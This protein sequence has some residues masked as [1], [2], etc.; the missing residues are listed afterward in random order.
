MSKKKRSTILESN[1]EAGGVLIEPVVEV[2][3]PSTNGELHIVF[4]APMGHCDD[5]YASGHLE[6]GSMLPR[7]AAALKR[8]RCSLAEQ[9]AR[10]QRRDAM[11]RDGKVVDS[12]ADAIRWILDQCADRFEALGQD[13]LEGQKF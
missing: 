1:S 3:P 5:G 4:D 6:V 11:H 12:N 10:T 8:I 9:A 7:Q 13:V 2:M